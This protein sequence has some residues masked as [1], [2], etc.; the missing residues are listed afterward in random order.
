MDNSQTLLHLLTT[1][2]PSKVPDLLPGQI[3]LGGQA[4]KRNTTC[5]YKKTEPEDR[6]IMPELYYMAAGRKIM[7]VGGQCYKMNEGDFCF[8]P[9][10]VRHYSWPVSP[11]R[12]YRVLLFGF[13][14]VQR[15]WVL[16]AEYSRKKGFKH[17]AMVHFKVSP[18]ILSLM[19]GPDGLGPASG[20]QAKECLAR[21]CPFLAKKIA[22]RDYFLS[23]F[24]EKKTWLQK[25]LVSIESYIREHLNEKLTL[26][27]IADQ[28]YMSTRSLV[29]LF[30]LEYGDTVFDYLIFTR[31]SRAITLLRERKLTVAEIAYQLNYRNAYYFSKQFKKFFG[32]TPTDYRHNYV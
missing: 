11:A 15:L 3:I 9:R 10:M 8:I 16:Y 17:L 12:P 4:H 31:L 29:H 5:S 30:K 13:Q 7:E 21:I 19:A 27:K 1:V 14:Q 6:H 22:D 25:S 18:A 20:H 26:K 24:K 2:L 32:I 28:F 23:P